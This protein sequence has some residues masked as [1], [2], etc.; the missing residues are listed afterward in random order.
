MRKLILSMMV[1]LDGFIEGPK[2]ELDWHVWDKEMDKYMI[3]FFDTIDTLLFGR[4]TYQLME[5][6]WPNASAPND[7]PIITGKMNNLP[8][9]VFSKT[10]DKADPI[11]TGW[12]NTTLLKKVN[13]E[14]IDK[15]KQQP[16]RNMVI[17]GGANLASTFL[18]MNLIDEYQV[19]VNP[20]ILGKGTPL[21]RDSGDKLTLQLLRTKA[22]SS[23]NVMLYYQPA[24][25]K[26]PKII[27]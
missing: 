3:N 17:F 22:F 12:Q 24:K 6:Y 9:I 13:A 26:A 7:D 4:I 20:V 23:G 10:L 14:E 1:S 18:D 16:G 25:N 2:K 21:F 19:I 11:I 5:S 15:M 8:K 27:K